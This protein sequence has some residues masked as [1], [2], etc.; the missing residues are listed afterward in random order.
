M[1]TP[2]FALLALA[3]GL[4]SASVRADEPAP[5]T[6]LKPLPLES[7]SRRGKLVY[8]GLD[9][10]CKA[11]LSAEIVDANVAGLLGPSG[12]SKKPVLLHTLRIDARE[13][14]ITTLNLHI[15]FDDPKK[16]DTDE[17]VEIIVT[18]KTRALSI[19]I[20]KHGAQFRR[21][22][23]LAARDARLAL[24]KAEIPKLQPDATV[25]TVS[26]A[27]GKLV[28]ARLAAE[29]RYDEDFADGCDAYQEGVKDAFEA[30][31]WSEDGMSDH[32]PDAIQIGGC[33]AADKLWNGLVKGPLSLSDVTELMMARQILT[34]VV[35]PAKKLGM[36]VATQEFSA[37]VPPHT[38]ILEPGSGLDDRPNRPS[39]SATTTLISGGDSKDLAVLD[40]A[41]L[42]PPGS[43]S[44]TFKV[45][46]DLALNLLDTQAGTPLDG[47]PNAFRARMSGIW[48]VPGET[49]RVVVTDN[50][51]GFSTQ[52][53][54]H[55]P[56]S[57]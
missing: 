17:A 42:L 24:I 13:P 33:Q 6:L 47:H 43:N 54:V 26:A 29:A 38:P 19:A 12:N 45:F 14:G 50:S 56:D 34:R 27:V 52:L 22:A 18:P 57:P 40:V 37:V 5:Y 16:T 46:G 55:A 39:L 28:D 9:K 32:V 49:Y 44:V 3:L 7:G 20:Q 21:A 35:N 2:H 51:T 10:D 4:L 8:Q 36:A 23:T 48:L 15:D 25:E 41:T 11:T 53:L 1:R 31:D 30:Q